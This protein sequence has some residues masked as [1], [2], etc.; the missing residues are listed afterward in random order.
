M[1]KSAEDFAVFVGNL[2]F[3]TRPEEQTIEAVASTM[4]MIMTNY[5]GGQLDFLTETDAMF[6]LQWNRPYKMYFSDGPILGV[7]IEEFESY[8]YEHV[9]IMTQRIGIKFE[10]KISDDLVKA[11]LTY[12]E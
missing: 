10:Y 2:H 12:L 5:P 3:M 7:T 9:S 11:T 8:C 4:H 1:G 6:V